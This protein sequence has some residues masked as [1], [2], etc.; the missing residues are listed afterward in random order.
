VSSRQVPD[1]GVAGELGSKALEAAVLVNLVLPI[2]QHV[3][4]TIVVEIPAIT[5]LSQPPNAWLY[6]VAIG[7][8]PPVLFVG[9]I[10]TATSKAGLA[11]GFAY[12]LMT[13]A[14]SQLLPN[15]VLSIIMLISIVVTLL[16]YFAAKMVAVGRSKGRSPRRRLYR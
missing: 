7:I 6:V 14:V 3:M 10:L 13:L 16:L 11:G 2:M 1:P 12:I 9:G 15:P 8:L 4:W 5:S